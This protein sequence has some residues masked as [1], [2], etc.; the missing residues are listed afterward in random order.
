MPRC[1]FRTPRLYVDADLDGHPVRLASLRGKAVWVNFWASWCGPCQ[2][3][4]PVLRQVAA[5]YRDRGLVVVGISVQESS[6]ADVQAA[7]R[8]LLKG[9][10]FETETASSRRPSPPPRHPSSPSTP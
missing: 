6:A 5:T 10:H 2:A 7:L 4:T 9:E 8:L 1:D 3:E